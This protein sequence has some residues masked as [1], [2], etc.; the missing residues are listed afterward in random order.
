MSSQLAKISFCCHK[1]SS[2]LKC[3]A[4]FLEFKNCFVL[5]Q[6][7]W[8]YQSN[9]AHV[10]HRVRFVTVEFQQPEKMKNQ[11]SFKHSVKPNTQ[12]TN[13]INVSLFEA[14]FCRVIVKLTAANST[15]RNLMWQLWATVQNVLTGL[16]NHCFKQKKENQLVITKKNNEHNPKLT[17]IVLG[18]WVQ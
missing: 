15:T 17:E 16:I 7:V 10:P 11:T 13:N 8:E 2:E 9:W 3:L 1:N 12:V 4:E 6:T 18:E 14:N 5:H